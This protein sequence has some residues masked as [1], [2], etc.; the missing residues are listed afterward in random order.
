MHFGF[1]QELPDFPLNPHMG[2]PMPYPYNGPV[3]PQACPN[4]GLESNNLTGWNQYC[5]V[6][7]DPINILASCNDPS[8]AKPVGQGNDPYGSFPKVFKG[9]YS[10]LL[11][12]NNVGRQ[13]DMVYFP[14]T[15]TNANKDF[16]FRYAVV[17]EDPTDHKDSEKPLFS[18]WCTLGNKNSPNPSSSTDMALYN[19]TVKTIVANRNNPFWSVN[20]NVVY[21]GWQCVSIDLSAYV[22]QT[23]SI[24]FL[25]KDC[26]LGGHFGYAYIDGL[27]DPDVLI[28][29]FYLPETICNNN[30]PII[31]DARAS[32][33][34][35]SHY[36]Q[37]I[38]ADASG[39]YTQVTEEWFYGQTAG[40]FDLKAWLAGKN[41]QLQCN[42]T[43]GLRLIVSNSC[44][45]WKAIGKFFKYTCPEINKTP[46]FNVCCPVVGEYCL[47]LEADI[48]VKNPNNPFPT[49]PKYY[50]NWIENPGGTNIGS[51]SSVHVCP[52][53]STQYIVT[54]TDKN[55][56][57][58]ADTINVYFRGPLSLE[59]LN[60]STCCTKSYKVNVKETPCS[61]ID[62]IN[63][64]TYPYSLNWTKNGQVISNSS[65]FNPP[66]NGGAYTVSA[67]NSCHTA[68]SSVNVNVDP[69]RNPN[70]NGGIAIAFDQQVFNG[71]PMPIYHYDPTGHPNNPVNWFGSP[72]YNAYG[73]R[74]EVYYR[75]NATSFDIA[76]ANLARVYETNGC[77]TMS[78]GDIQIDGYN[79]SGNY[80]QQGSY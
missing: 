62:A 22:G 63:N 42:K 39:N 71:N 34:E 46:D 18:Y 12:N 19:T 57:T 31:I 55:N 69:I 60:Q 14:I 67:S 26:D 51:N 17:L 45:P 23:V 32:M 79:S 53:K 61:A 29:D 75:W 15:V 6:Y 48:N 33:G 3:K 47:T 38:V 70:A 74:I 52:T 76:P 1:S 49:K 40:L 66:E 20:G 21:K 16:K 36:W 78:N 72:A 7:T 9:N 77:N 5:G 54:V 35:D 68:I 8:R 44:S 41:I 4:G 11:G 73:Y 59:V 64:S 50:Y 27:C 30:I 58:N 13:L 25:V 80:L 56:C 65:T 10:L 24:C 43:Y 2:Y 28:P 37:L